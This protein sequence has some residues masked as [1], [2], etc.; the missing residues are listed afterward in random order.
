MKLKTTTKLY[1][2]IGVFIIGFISLYSVNKVFTG[3]ISDLDQQTQNLES[4]IRLIKSDIRGKK[5]ILKDLP[6]KKLT[7]QELQKSFLYPLFYLL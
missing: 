5:S 7:N 6:A 3:L 4:K 2:L 1:F